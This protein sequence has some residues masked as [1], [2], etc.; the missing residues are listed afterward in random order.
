MLLFTSDHLE[1]SL[2]TLDLIFCRS[3]HHLWSGSKVEALPS[4]AQ[5]RQQLFHLFIFTVILILQVVEMSASILSTPVRLRS[6]T[7]VE[8]TR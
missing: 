3:P 2:T 4:V 7:H 5:M 8:P 6:K 1:K